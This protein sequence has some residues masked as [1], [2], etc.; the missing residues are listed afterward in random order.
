[1]SKDA[2][3]PRFAWGGFAASESSLLLDK[4]HDREPREAKVN[5]ETELKLLA[6]NLTRA[7]ARPGSGFATSVN[8]FARVRLANRTRDACAKTKKRTA[9]KQ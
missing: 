5:N 1:M 2:L 7:L 3:R 8:S 4:L 9:T 6:K